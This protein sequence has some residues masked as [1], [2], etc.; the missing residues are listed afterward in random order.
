MK[1]S[2]LRYAA[3]G[4]A[5]LSLAG[6]AAASTVSLGTTGPNSTNKVTLK[7]TLSDTL[8]NKNNVGVVNFSAQGAHSGDV[9]ANN[10]TTVDDL[11][12]GAASND[13]SADTTVTISNSS[14]AFGA[15]DLT[16]PDDNVSI[17]TT[18]PNSNNQV[19][20]E[21]KATIKTTNT[22]NVDVYNVNLQSATS[23][24]VSAH[25]NTTV[26]GLTSG[27]ATNTNAATTT[28]DITN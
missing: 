26:G 1:V 9:K 18:G 3:I 5:T 20:I 22:N 11:S 4:M 13:N 25:N 27:D 2:V 16:P 24:D 8:T 19:T 21:N 12:S 15:G 23:G 7:N 14:S 28:V 10:N 6:F 17:D